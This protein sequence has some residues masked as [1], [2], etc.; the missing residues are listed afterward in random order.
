MTQYQKVR[1]TSGNLARW[2]IKY[3]IQESQRVEWVGGVY[4]ITTKAWLWTPRLTVVRREFVTHNP[5]LS[6]TMEAEKQQ[7][8]IDLAGK[9]NLWVEV[10]G[11]N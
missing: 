7:A 1:R 2:A 5:N 6:P 4:I 3:D 11:E 9:Y 10:Q 8:L